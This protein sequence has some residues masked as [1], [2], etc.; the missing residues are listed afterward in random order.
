MAVSLAALEESSAKWLDRQRKAVDALNAARADLQLAIARHETAKAKVR[1]ARLARQQ[2]QTPV[3]HV[4]A[5][6]ERKRM[7]A[8]LA[9]RNA[10]LKA[11]RAELVITNAR[12]RVDNAY[13]QME[14]VEKGEGFTL[15][16]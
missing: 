6:C 12:I 10:E 3:C 5:E 9:L 8:L 7:K 1:A 16:A 4:D 15:A 13:W 14:Q 11:V 2:A